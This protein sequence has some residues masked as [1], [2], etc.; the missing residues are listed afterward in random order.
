[1]ATLVRPVNLDKSKEAFCYHNHL[2]GPFDVYWIGSQMDFK[3][4]QKSHKAQA[5]PFEYRLLLFPKKK[6][7][8]K[9][10]LF[11]KIRNLAS[12]RD[13]SIINIC[14]RFLFHTFKLARYS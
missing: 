2:L 13:Q 9:F 6:D 10:H 1:M 8:R 12:A 11:V 4:K 14:L 5:Q 7:E 3:Q